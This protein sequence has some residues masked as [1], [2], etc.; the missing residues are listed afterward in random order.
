MAFGKPALGGKDDVEVR[1]LALQSACTVQT[2]VIDVCMC[3]RSMMF[4]RPCDRSILWASRK[5]RYNNNP[6]YMHVEFI[7]F[8]IMSKEWSHALALK[9]SEIERILPSLRLQEGLPVL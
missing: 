7:K 9:S 1:Q 5:H 6:V 2:G 4:L 8:L 3:T